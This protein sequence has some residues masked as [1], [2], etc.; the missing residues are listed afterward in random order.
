MVYCF[1]RSWVFSVQH[2][3]RGWGLFELKYAN[4]TY[5]GILLVMKYDFLE[6]FADQAFRIAFIS[7]PK[8]G[9]KA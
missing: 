6:F 3:T 4:L 5:D 7:R 9:K 8:S 2:A 1:S